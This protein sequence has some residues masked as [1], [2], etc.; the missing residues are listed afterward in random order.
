MKFTVDKDD[1]QISLST[2]QLNRLLL[3]KLSTYQEQDYIK[4]ADK[5][6]EDLFL[7]LP[8]EEIA[9]YTLQQLL[10]LFFISGYYYNSFTTKNNVTI[11]TENS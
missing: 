2:L 11:S 9:K 7:A 3:K 10:Q 6:V 1:S 4:H 8:S 5:I